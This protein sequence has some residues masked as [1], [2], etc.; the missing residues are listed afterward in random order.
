MN[1]RRSSLSLSLSLCVIEYLSSNV[2]LLVRS[3]LFR[4]RFDDFSSLSSSPSA[5]QLVGRLPEISI[6]AGVVTVRLIWHGAAYVRNKSARARGIQRPRLDNR[7]SSA[8]LTLAHV[9][10]GDD[11]VCV[12]RRTRSAKTRLI[13]GSGF[14]CDD[15]VLCSPSRGCVRDSDLA[16]HGR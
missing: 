1:S 6:C 4:H 3:R 8:D 10:S 5:C 11:V 15:R 2:F 16:S 14:S 13:I 7:L 9:V 12:D